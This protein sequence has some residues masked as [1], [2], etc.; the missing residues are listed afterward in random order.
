MAVIRKST[1]NMV[2]DALALVVLAM[3]AGTGF[4]I[5][6]KLP[7]GSGGGEGR[8]GAMHGS[9]LSVLGLTRHGWGDVHLILAFVLAALIAVHLVSHWQW[10]RTMAKVEGGPSG[11]MRKAVMLVAALV[12]ILFVVLPFLITPTRFSPAG[13]T[14]TETATPA[15]P[16]PASAEESDF[17]YGALTIDEVS[18][19]TG[20]STQRIADILGIEG[21]LNGDEKLGR[22]LRSHGINMQDARRKLRQ[23]APRRGESSRDEN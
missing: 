9:G 8:F 2:V 10:I 11:G 6:Y 5:A 22:L 4:L 14:P 20:L 17:L 15:V 13:R 12:S 18:R 16:S 1:F 7:P 19:R 23:A 21:S 3:L